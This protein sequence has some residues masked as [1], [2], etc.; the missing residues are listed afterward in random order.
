MKILYFAW[1]AERLGCPEE[2][3]PLPQEVKN[4]DDVR[5]FLQQ[6]YPE[7]AAILD[8]P[9]ALRVAVN[10]QLVDWDYPVQC[11]DEVALFPPM[12]GG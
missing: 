5:R 7:Q 9:A 2:D 8:D 4:A 1:L 11:N 10:Q 12:T 6:R 3:L